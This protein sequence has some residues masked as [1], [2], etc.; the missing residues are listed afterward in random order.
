[1]NALLKELKINAEKF[2]QLFNQLVEAYK[3]YNIL[4]YIYSNISSYPKYIINVLTNNIDIQ[5][6]I[7]LQKKLITALEQKLLILCKTQNNLRKKLLDLSHSGYPTL[8]QMIEQISYGQKPYFSVKTIIKLNFKN[9]FTS[10]FF[11]NNLGIQHS[12][13]YLKIA[14]YDFFS[15]TTSNIKQKLISGIRS[16][17]EKFKILK[18]SPT[19]HDGYVLVF[20][21][22]SSDTVTAKDFIVYS[23]NGQLLYYLSDIA[24]ELVYSLKHIKDILNEKNIFFTLKD[25]IGFEKLINK[26]MR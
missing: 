2:N 19:H 5:K 7:D 13:P 21:N 9:K 11:F 24:I 18:N 23:I 12:Y 8:K 4:I 16:W 25:D 15:P 17:L 1:M 26:M 3:K 10:T 6:A 20:S 22:N 14:G